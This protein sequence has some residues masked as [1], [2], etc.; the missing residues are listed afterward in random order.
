MRR[1]GVFDSGIGGIT[2]LE[3]LRKNLVGSKFFYL[4]DTS[5]VPYGTKSPAQIKKL[6]INC[7]E[8]LKGLNLDAV[9]VACNTASSVA[10]V[11]IQTVMGKVPVLGVIGAG[12]ESILSRLKSSETFGSQTILVMATR[13]TVN[14]AIYSR[15]LSEKL[16][17]QNGNKSSRYNI[18]EQ[19]CPLLVP[20]IEE[21]WISHPI[22]IRTIEEYVE[23]HRKKYSSGLVLLG[24][25]H[26]PYIQ[27]QISK[28]L[29]SWTVV[30]S[31]GEV[32]RQLNNLQIPGL[33]MRDKTNTLSQD[34]PPCE[35]IFTDPT[36]VPSFVTDLIQK[37]A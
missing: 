16:N 11:E 36:A 8:I 15:Q 29:P 20:M 12:V 3:E 32:I 25:T 22:L 4:G 21:G 14:S 28:I 30:N 9:V 18:V 24:C 33:K 1:I 19:A 10:L 17:L 5:N 23:P 37:A 13:A 2:I 31:A 34:L 27:E 35:W 7:A 26:Y 6:C